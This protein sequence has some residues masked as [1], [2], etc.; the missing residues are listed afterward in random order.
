MGPTVNSQSGPA[1]LPDT[2]VAT[3]HLSLGVP[4][5]PPI[6]TDKLDER[7]SSAMAE[8]ATLTLADKIDFTSTLLGTRADSTLLD[9]E[10]N[11]PN[12]R[13]HSTMVIPP[14]SDSS[15]FFR[16][17][18]WCADGSSL[19]GVTEHASLEILNVT[20]EGD[21]VELK[22]QLSLQQ[23]APILSTAWFPTAST[24]DAASYCFVAAI[25]DT[26]IKL[27]DAS[28]GR[29]RASYKIIDHRE[30]FI[31]PHSMAFNMY[32]SRLYCGFEDA[33]EVFDVHYPGEGT[34]LHTVPTKKSRDGIRGI[35]SSLAFTPDWT[36]TYAVGSF[37]GAIA[38]Y[39]EDT[40]SQVQSWLEGT[41]GGV[42]QIRFNPTQAHI[43]YAAFRRTPLIAR[44]DLRNPSEPDILYHRGLASTNQRMGF[45]LSPDGRWVIAGDERG[46]VSVFDAVGEEGRVGTVGA[47]QDSMGAISFHPTKPYV[48][49][50]SGSRHFED[51]G[52]SASESEE[53]DDLDLEDLEDVEGIV[54]GAGVRGPVLP[55]R[56]TGPTVV[57]NS[58]KLWSLQ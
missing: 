35:I 57:D 24:L 15:N 20:D 32:M 52:S 36:G 7:V 23:P 10:A 53:S 11:Q 37:D 48:V 17:I 47:H 21:H 14:F 22:H 44:W 8:T 51:A 43:V 39:T 42:T 25:R 58:L 34:R 45:D 1:P 31:A 5:D 30:R 56:K 40:G 6:S 16:N 12:L 29:V 46:Q 4:E 49:S 2:V 13:P 18:Q 26:P 50:V 19:L 54:S 33:I 3:E 27:F 9:I 55:R 38:L 28:D 41:E